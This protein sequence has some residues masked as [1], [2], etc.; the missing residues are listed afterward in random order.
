MRMG[1][2]LFLMVFV[3]A[4]Q[5]STFGEDLKIA[6]L[7]MERVFQEYYK[8]KIAD[9]NIKKQAEVFKSYTEKLVDSSDRLQKEY[10]DLRDASQNIGLSDAERESKRI[11]AKKKYDQLQ[12]KIAETKQYHREKQTQ[13][14][15]EYESNRAKLLNEIK[16][17]IEKKSALENYTIVFDISGKTLNNIP[18]V[19]HYN[20]K[21]E[22]TDVI[23]E[24]LNRG[25]KQE[26]PG[27][28]TKSEVKTDSKAAAPAKDAAKT[29]SKANTKDAKTESP[30]TNKTTDDKPK[31]KSWF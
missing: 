14:K 23:L 6:M 5:Y 28:N 2:I 7:D 12:E 9:A 25:H 19:I 8:T 13:L 3:F 30:N 11:E 26:K 31:A 16:K 17:E 10:K 18:A 15:D 1:K 29:D 27:K 4:C 20:K 21:Y 24:E 22:I